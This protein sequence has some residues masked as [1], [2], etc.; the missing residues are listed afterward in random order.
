MLNSDASTTFSLSASEF[1]LVEENIGKDALTATWTE[2]DFGYTAG[3]NYMVVFSTTETELDDVNTGDSSFKSL[4][5][6]VIF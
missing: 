5:V 4:T 6:I 2:P 1:V 3:P